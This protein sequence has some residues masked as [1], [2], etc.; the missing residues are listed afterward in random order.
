M[1]NKLIQQIGFVSDATLDE[2]S[3]ELL[4]Q[5]EQR[6]QEANAIHDT[7]TDA[8]VGCQCKVHLLFD[9]CCYLSSMNIV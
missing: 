7:T 4:A 8:E 9:C 6:A 5:E 3:C 2:E 1:K